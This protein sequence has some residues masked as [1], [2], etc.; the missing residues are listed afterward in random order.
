MT[1]STIFRAW[2]GA[3]L[4]AAAV[5]PAAAETPIPPEARA[6]PDPA[7]K[8][9]KLP[10]GMRY[11]LMR[12]ATPPGTVSIRLALDVGS[13]VEEDGERGFAHFVEHMAFRST[14]QLPQGVLDNHFAA[15]GISF[16][17]D[18]NAGTGLTST[19]YRVDL[20]S[21]KTGDVRTI[22]DWMRG[23]ADGILF[24]PTAVDLERNVVLTERQTLQSAQ[25][26]AQLAIGRFQAA[27]LRSAERDPGGEVETLR[28]ATPAALQAFYDRWYR[29]ENATLVIVGDVAAA[30]VETLVREV[31]AG[32][33]ARGT[34]GVRPPVPETLPERGPEA[35]SHAGEGLAAFASLC[36][37]QP[38]DRD[39]SGSLERMRRETY[40]A[41]WS[42]ILNRRLH[43]S[44][45][46]GGSPLLAAGAG[47][48][49]DAPEYLGS[50]LMVLPAGE[51]WDDAL[52]TALAELRRL[53]EEG[54]TE[55]EVDEAIEGLRAQL[56]AQLEKAATRSSPSLAESIVEAT[57]SERVFQSPQEAMRTY[58][59]VVDGITPE[60][61]GRAL[62]RDWGKS[63]PLIAAAGAKPPARD[64]L[65]AA[66]EAGANADPL[67]SYADAEEAVWHYSHF[68]KKGKVKKRETI[69]DP[70][71]VRL[72]FKNGVVMHF[73]QTNFE[74]GV[75]D[76][77]IRFGHGERGL[78][79]EER[80]AAVIGGALFAAGGLGRMS[81][82]DISSVFGHSSWSLM[83]TPE[84]DAFTISSTFFASDIALQT[85]LAA[86]YM[87]DPGFGPL[88]DD[89][90]GPVL[91]L[92]Y[93]GVL[94]NPTA[95]A[96]DVLDR[97]LFPKQR[98][99][100]PRE[101]LAKLRA[102]DFAR[103]LKPALSA[104]PIE[105]TVVG[106]IDEKRA[107]QAVARTFGALPPRKPL[108]APAAGPFR[109]FPE[110]LP[111]TLSG[112]HM[113]LPDKAAALVVWPL[114]VASDARRRE[115]YAIQLVSSILQTR[116]L[117]RVRFEMGKVYAP[118]VQN[119]MPDDADQGQIAASVETSAADLDQVVAAVLAVA[120]EL[121]EGHITQQE[122]DEAKKPALADRRRMRTTNAAWAGVLS[123]SLRHPAALDE[124]FAYEQQLSVITL[125][126][127]KQAASTWLGRDPIVSTARPARAAPAA[128]N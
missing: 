73:R 116:L 99:A 87:T 24:T 102:K 122:V 90:L 68:G 84:P 13:L 38:A 25:A 61:I 75:V 6:A 46:G 19:V 17:R 67:E 66:W 18:Q 33:H 26:E 40:S 4:L 5:S 82:D 3:L 50:C 112:E 113:G 91:D 118:D 93:A 63:G 83:L 85:Q 100:P 45:N 35:Y 16:G 95:A 51:R 55:L 94:E 62:D 96:T 44:S 10:N 36:S 114:Y 108:P 69:P 59:I 105:V 49:R 53:R 124:L 92:A 81:M 88:I 29:P 30:E 12:N 111:K 2:A 58:D 32:W 89:K 71:F 9:G 115:E 15:L 7:V 42:R 79:E 104:A 77:R 121:A 64:A 72:T 1:L 47:V 52:A 119:P 57:L 41:L 98:S 20:P 28:A 8:W 60:D 97:A 34:A 109:R 76:M 21:T 125:D 22:L 101:E 27:G 78:A 54:P 37:L 127:V 31:F 70:G 48:D 80:G 107:V 120:R 123:Q 56:R 86:A 11:A 103:M 106:D 74:A 65:L 128:A 43:K 117:Q 126:E 23:A 39:R 110:T 14:R